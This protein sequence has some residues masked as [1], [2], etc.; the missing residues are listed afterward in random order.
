MAMTPAATPSTRPGVPADRRVGYVL[1]IAV[2]GLMVWISHRLLDWGWPGFLTEAYDDV[3]W[4]ITVSLLASMAA[5]AAFLLYDRGRFRPFADLVVAAIGFLLMIRIW[6]V[7]PFDFSGYARD[8][9]WLVRMVAVIAIGGTAIGVIV[10]LVKL[11]L[12]GDR[13]AG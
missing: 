4:L 8:W 6:V 9:S 11:I 2:N 7:F 13:S 1:A 10:N 3:L 12:P 5:N